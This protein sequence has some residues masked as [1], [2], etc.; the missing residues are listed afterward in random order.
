M[1]LNKG[2]KMNITVRAGDITRVKS[3]AIV[4]G[5]FEGIKKPDGELAIVA[6]ALDGAISQM[7]KRGQLKGKLGELNLIQS[8]GS[9]PSESV[10]I[11]GLGKESELTPER[12]RGAVG[13]L[14]RSLRQKWIDSVA[15]PPLGAGHQG[16]TLEESA[17]AIAEGALL[18]LYTFR[19]YISK[20]PEYGEI[21]E[22]TI[23]THGT[24]EVTKLKKGVELGQVMAQSAN[25]A[26]DMVNEPSNYKT[27]AELAKIAQ[28]LADQHR[29]EITILE[30]DDMEKLGMGA[31]LG[32]SQGSA[33]PPK[34]II[35]SYKGRPAEVFDLAL[36]GK[37]IT[38]DSGGISLK[39][40]E[41]MEDMKG[42]MAG[43]A[44]VMAAISAI[45]RLKPG[46]NAVAVVAAVEN[47]PG[48][49]AYR[50]GDVLHAMNGKTV[51]VISTDAEGRL[52]LADALSYVN[53]KIKAKHIVDI[54]TLTGA[55]V[56]A[57]GH[58]ASAVFTNNQPLA[59]RVL[60]A[61]KKAGELSWQMPM[62]EEYKEQNR[63]EIADMKNV[64]GR[65]AGAITAA[66]FL[67]EFAGDT[68][69]VHMDIA[70]VNLTE[71]ERKH[72]VKGATGIPVRT[73]VNL[74]LDMAKK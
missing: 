32:V 35:L 17:Q 49:H 29:L 43:G 23:L 19:K 41:K 58:V 69:W 59:E 74:A 36:V 60:A 18:G 71:K 7:I 27:P 20:K 33:H 39:P 10:A 64:G 45:A 44:S 16:I 22:L 25:L 26:R 11:L 55:C 57:L 13:E 21:T 8:L 63:S 6:A 30:K 3:A 54:A 46:I 52:T 4:L 1:S 72:Y 38:F 12:V 62:F 68:P 15:L 66:Q 37:G 2:D 61:G 67:A 48:G 5:V 73:L 9:L 42:D 34:F 31:L 28:K 53:A 50:P 70:G 14:C 56:V 40:T 47:L 24:T 51:E 65:P